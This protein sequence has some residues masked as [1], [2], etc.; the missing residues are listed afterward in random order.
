[1]NIEQQKRL[2]GSFGFN[3]CA[4][5]RG[6][7]GARIIPYEIWERAFDGAILVS[8]RAKH[9]KMDGGRWAEG[10]TTLNSLAAWI[11]P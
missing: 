11:K 1:M 8:Y 2:A 6:N 4:E 9:P 5:Y 10:D 3:L 7:N